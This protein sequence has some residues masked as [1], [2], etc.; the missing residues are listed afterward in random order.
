MGGSAWRGG[1]AA[2]L[3]SLALLLALVAAC[4]PAAPRGPAAGGPGAMPSASGE[5][6]PVGGS[7]PG[8]FTVVLVSPLTNYNPYSQSGGDITN[9]WQSIFQ[10]LVRMTNERTY[11]P[12]VAERWEAVAPTTW[13]FHIRPGIRFSDGSPLTAADVKHSIVDRALDDPD[14]TRRSSIST[15]QDAT[16]VDDL[17]VDVVTKVPNATLLGQLATIPITSKALYDRVGKEA[18]D[19]QPVS[20]G[21]YVL[22]E[23]VP[24]QRLV[25]RKNP[26]YWGDITSAPDE[27]VIRWLKEPMVALTALLSGEVDMTAPLPPNLTPQLTGNVRAIQAPSGFL[28][29]MGLGAVG[30]LTNKTVRQAIN[31]AVDKDA[32][33]NGILK[34]NAQRAD[35]PLIDT[36]IGYAPDVTPRYEYDPARARQLL[37]QAGYPDGFAMDLYHPV[38]RFT[39]DVDIAAALAAQLGQVGIQVTLKPTETSTFLTQSL[40][41]AYPAFLYGAGAIDEPTRYLFQFFHQSGRALSGWHS[42]EVDRLLEAQIAEFDPAKR[43]ALLREL[44]AALNDEAPAVWLLSFTNTIGISNH[45]EWPRLHGSTIYFDTI[46]AR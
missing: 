17:T 24:D 27:V 6:A 46:R 9:A 22:H 1:A 3:S 36:S 35:V 10:G 43:D 28:Y 5:A 29:F 8:R 23:L 26:Y 11:E 15:V 18:A 21:P 42:A 39:N 25:M 33:I 20:A 30:P 13:R 44:Q 4:A 19:R 31:Y 32:I 37:A 40:A 45:W 7:G 16:V 34:G 2:R 38:G 12:L 14:S 41:G